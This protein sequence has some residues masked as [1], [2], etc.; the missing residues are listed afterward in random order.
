MVS[1]KQLDSVKREK[2]FLD[3]LCVGE[4]AKFIGSTA[5]GLYD[6]NE[7]DDGELIAGRG[8]GVHEVL[9]DG[10]LIRLHGGTRIQSRPCLRWAPD[11]IRVDKG[12]EGG[13][14]RQKLLWRRI[15]SRAAPDLRMGDK[16]LYKHDVL[17]GSS[18]GAWADELGL[19]PADKG[20]FRKKEKPHVDEQ[21]DAGYMP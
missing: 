14:T 15:F 2:D 17:V 4:D 3:D 9:H 12:H 10:T 6:I 16:P 19:F 7:E 1:C 11:W 18:L 13:S 5:V 20:L 21:K 8:G